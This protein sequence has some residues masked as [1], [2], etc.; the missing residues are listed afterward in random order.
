MFRINQALV[1][2]IF[3]FLHSLVF[4]IDFIV[5][6]S[7]RPMVTPEGIKNMVTLVG[8][9]KV[10]FRVFGMKLNIDTGEYFKLA[11]GS[12]VE[13]GYQSSRK[14]W[15]LSSLC[16]SHSSGRRQPYCQQ[17]SKKGRRLWKGPVS[18][19][20]LPPSSHSHRGHQPPRASLG[21]PHTF[22]YTCTGKVTLVYTCTGLPELVHTHVPVNLH[23][24]TGALWVKLKRSFEF[25]L[26]QD[27]INIFCSFIVIRI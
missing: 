17:D 5:S 13:N 4:F 14:H 9:K 1:W 6:G 10:N 3:A 23:R 22:R 12:Q 20:T 24:Y 11:L 7:D 8:L 15:A 16:V 2:C 19:S 21:Q 27:Y 26:V 25:S 18:R